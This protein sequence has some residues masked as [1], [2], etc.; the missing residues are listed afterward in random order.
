MSNK[1]MIKRITFRRQLEQLINKHSMENG[2]DSPDFILAEY[3]TDCLKAFDSAT[4]QRDK[5]YNR[6]GQDKT[7]KGD[8]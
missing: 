5:W 4:T 8:G 1:E 7:E 2:S 6:E 3:L